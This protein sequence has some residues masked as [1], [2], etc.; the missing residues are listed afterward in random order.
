MMEKD[1]TPVIIGSGVLLFVGL[2]TSC[3]ADS[4]MPVLIAIVSIAV[5]SSYLHNVKL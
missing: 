4:W 2:G 3:I 5:A 1:Y